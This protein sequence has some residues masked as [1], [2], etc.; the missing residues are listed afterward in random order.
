MRED[1]KRY[2][3]RCKQYQQHADWHKAP[4]EELKSIYSPWHVPHVGNRHSGTLPV[5]D[6]A[7]E[8][9]GCGD[10]VLHEMDWGRTSSLDHRAQNPEFC[11]EEYCVSFWR[12]QASSIRQWDSVRKPPVEEAVRGHRDTTGVCF[13]GTPANEWASGVC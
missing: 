7:N 6:Q 10:R 13:R 2:A 12:A 5:G 3:Q 9:F 8:V 11:V 1:C 4:P